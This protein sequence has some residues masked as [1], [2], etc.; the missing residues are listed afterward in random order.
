MLNASI[1]ACGTWWDLDPTGIKIILFGKPEYPW[2]QASWKMLEGKW[3]I[4]SAGEFLILRKV[5]LKLTS[6]KGRF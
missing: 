3:R 5:I 6:Y 4:L 2:P 1:S